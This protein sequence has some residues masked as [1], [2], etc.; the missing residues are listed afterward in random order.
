MRGILA[1]A[2]CALSIAM[3][4]VLGV[5]HIHSS[6]VDHDASRGLHLDHAHPT[7]PVDHH[8]HQHHHPS[9][10]AAAAGLDSS[11]HHGDAVSLHARAVCGTPPVPA[12]LAIVSVQPTIDPPAAMPAL[13]RES[14]TR[15]R[16]PPRRDGP[17]L[18][19]PPA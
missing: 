17:P 19:A 3:G 14:Q 1:L 9:T 11:H 16:D 18:R 8:H 7:D 13:V 15:P 6:A 12:G 10:E 4:P 5:A 2:C